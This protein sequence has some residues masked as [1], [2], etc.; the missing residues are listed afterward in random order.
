[1]T[2]FFHYLQSPHAKLYAKGELV[3]RELDTE[4]LAGHTMSRP[5]ADLFHTFVLNE[6]T[7]AQLSHAEDVFMAKLGITLE[8]II[9]PDG[10]ISDERIAIDEQ[11]IAAR[12]H[13]PAPKRFGFEI[14]S[15]DGKRIRAIVV[16]TDDN[17]RIKTLMDAEK[18]IVTAYD[19]VV[20]DDGN[21]EYAEVYP[22][23]VVVR[24]AVWA[25]PLTEAMKLHPEKVENLPIEFMQ[26][27]FKYKNKPQIGPAADEVV[28]KP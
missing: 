9:E 1:M 6:T 5:P 24:P 3:R 22:A 16:E 17:Q 11:F 21:I 12:L 8:G 7:M 4:V 18:V 23:A 28:T 20:G 25:A 14:H 15:D 26:F 2:V 19:A 10:V 27:K 13:S